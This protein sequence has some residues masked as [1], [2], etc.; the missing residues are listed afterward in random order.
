MCNQA[1]AVGAG[2]GGHVFLPPRDKL[3]LCA[4]A[5]PS[6]PPGTPLDDLPLRTTDPLHFLTH[7]HSDHLAGL[8]SKSF[9]YRVTCS[10]DTK[11]ILLHYEYLERSLYENG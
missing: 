5:T 4:C 10:Q 3:T 9:G 2:I 11:W 6:M 7:A 8:A 1:V